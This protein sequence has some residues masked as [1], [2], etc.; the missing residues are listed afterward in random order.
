[1]ITPLLSS[2]GIHAQWV[3][4][5]GPWGGNIPDPAACGD[6]VFAVTSSGLFMSTIPLDDVFNIR[7]AGHSRIISLSLSW[8]ER[9]TVGILTFQAGKLRRL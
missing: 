9:I 1:M 2:S 7:A 3:Q 4:S 8:P 6:T 5:S